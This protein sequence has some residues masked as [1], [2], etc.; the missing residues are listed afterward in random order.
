MRSV[1]GDSLLRQVDALEAPERDAIL[2]RINPDTLEHYRRAKAIGWSAMTLHMD[3]SDCIRAVIGPRRN[4]E[5]WRDTMADLTRRPML[6][7]F[8][9]HIG[10]R[11]GVGPGT[12]YRQNA[13]LWKYLCRNVGRLDA[14]VA[15]NEATVDL[16]GF[17]ASDHHFPCFVEGLNGC[18]QGLVAGIDV[19]PEVEVV[20]VDPDSGDARY[21]I[22]W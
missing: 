12:L 21:H 22:A 14:E 19:V 1:F 15:A 4:V 20:S 8:L 16:S 9:R 5:L 18:L 7:G 2:T 13:R 17:P 11:L 6:S 10:A 3:V